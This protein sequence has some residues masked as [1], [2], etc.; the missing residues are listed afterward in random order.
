[1]LFIPPVDILTIIIRLLLPYPLVLPIIKLKINLLHIF[2]LFIP[3]RYPLFKLV[4]HLDTFGHLNIHQLPIV[5]PVTCFMFW[6]RF[7]FLIGL[8]MGLK[9]FEEL[10]NSID[11]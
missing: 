7:Y 6:F 8:C 11:S 1:M 2:I 9:L 3:L 4:S 5:L 10:S